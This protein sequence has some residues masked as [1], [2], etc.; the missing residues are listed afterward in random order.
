M[1]RAS[2]ESSK[3]C[4]HSE[5]L[6]CVLV[7]FNVLYVCFHNQENASGTTAPG[8]AFTF[9]K[10]FR[11]TQPRPSSLPTLPL[12]PLTFEQS[13]SPSSYGEGGG[14]PTRS[15]QSSACKNLI[16]QISSP[17]VSFRPY[18]STVFVIKL[19]G[20]FCSGKDV[21]CFPLWWRPRL[22]PHSAFIECSQQY[23]HRGL[24]WWLLLWGVWRRRDRGHI[25]SALWHADYSN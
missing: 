7:V 24:Q 20:F 6:C 14:L 21:P 16:K 12:S 15:F 11:F 22:F 23:T 2:I 5:F 8:E 13:S 1:K 10:P 3:V 17:L 25:S 4:N 18:F 9:T 19:F